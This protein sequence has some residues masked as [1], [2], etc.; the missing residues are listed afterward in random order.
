MVLEFIAQTRG[1][2]SSAYLG[3]EIWGQLEVSLIYQ[4]RLVKLQIS[5]FSVKWDSHSV[6][7]IVLT[8]SFDSSSVP[9]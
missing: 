1:K 2:D 8:W 9:N 4:P 6:G 5:S 7:T 3:Q